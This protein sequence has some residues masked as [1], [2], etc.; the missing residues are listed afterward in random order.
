MAEYFQKFTKQYDS[1]NSEV[2]KIRW[3][4]KGLKSSVQQDVASLEPQTFDTAVR[5]AFW[6]EEENESHVKMRNVL[7]SDGDSCPHTRGS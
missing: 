7:A 4:V 6:F 1:I 3:F 5:R 2:I